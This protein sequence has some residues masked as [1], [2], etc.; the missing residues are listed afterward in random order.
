M[1]GMGGNVVFETK[2]IAMKS[3]LFMGYEASLRLGLKMHVSMVLLL[4]RKTS[5]KAD[6]PV[7]PACVFF[8]TWAQI[9]VAHCPII[10]FTFYYV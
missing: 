2:I 8:P 5:I 7:I 6:V 4:T 1:Q 10:S 9:I 3:T